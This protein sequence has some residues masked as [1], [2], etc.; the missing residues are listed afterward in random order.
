M[1]KKVKIKIR[2]EIKSL[3]QGPKTNIVVTLLKSIIKNYIK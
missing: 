2:K 1:K 3:S